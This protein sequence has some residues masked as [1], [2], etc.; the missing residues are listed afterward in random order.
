MGDLQSDTR[1]EGGAGRYRGRSSEDWDGAPGRR[2]GGFRSVLALRAVGEASELPRPVSSTGI[3]RFGDV[4]IEVSTLSR[5]DW[6]AA[7]RVS[8]TQ[9]E[10]PILDGS[11]WTAAGDLPGY[12]VEFAAIPEYPGPEGLPSVTEIAARAGGRLW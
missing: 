10:A 2:A 11:L 12:T 8:M 9:S 4:E 1:L 7:L 6:T 3:P 5:S